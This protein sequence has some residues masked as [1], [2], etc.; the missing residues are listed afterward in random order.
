MYMM[1]YVKKSFLCMIIIVIC[2]TVW[3]CSGD[4][5]LD[6]MTIKLY[7]ADGHSLSDKQNDRLE[8]IGIKGT[9]GSYSSVFSYS[10]LPD[11]VNEV[12][13]NIE[14]LKDKKWKV[15]KSIKADI[16]GDSAKGDIYISQYSALEGKCEVISNAGKKIAEG[17]ITSPPF[18]GNGIGSYTIAT[19][20]TF[21]VK[22]GVPVVF[23]IISTGDMSAFTTADTYEKLYN[24]PDNEKAYQKGEDYFVQTI[25]FRKK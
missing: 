15:I 9:A 3:S 5:S 7:A 10:V 13:I 22:D 14:Q 4:G 1:K 11:Q 8:D 20:E 16:D 23:S 2:L 21:P 17:D 6:D 18:K 24:E 12:E 25:T 19:E